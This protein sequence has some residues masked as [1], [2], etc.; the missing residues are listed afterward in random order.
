MTKLIKGTIVISIS[1]LGG[2]GYLVI[3]HFLS[4]QSANVY[5]S[6]LTNNIRYL[7]NARLLGSFYTQQLSLMAARPT[8]R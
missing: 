3:D 8:Q 2:V 6:I 4:S 1:I 5:V 7:S